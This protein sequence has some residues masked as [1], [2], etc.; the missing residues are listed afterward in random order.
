DPF[1]LARAPLPVRG[2]GLCLP[3]GEGHLRTARR[4]RWRSCPRAA[5]AWSGRSCAIAAGNFATSPPGQEPPT[6]RLPPVRQAKP[7]RRLG[8]PCPSLL[9]AY[10]LAGRRM[11]PDPGRAERIF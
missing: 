8:F 3:Q 5:R 10:L 2:G 9:L 4:P 11:S 6:I 1:V 7:S